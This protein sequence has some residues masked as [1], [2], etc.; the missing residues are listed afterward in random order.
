MSIFCFDETA[1]AK[2]FEGSLLHTCAQDN[3]AAFTAVSAHGAALRNILLAAPSDN[4]IAAFAS[5]KC[6][7]NR[8]NKHI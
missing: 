5:S 1:I 2:A 6:D 7:F 8:I 4:A 3:R